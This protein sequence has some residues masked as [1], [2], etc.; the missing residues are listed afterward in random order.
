[1]RVAWQLAGGGVEMGQPDSRA[2]ER[3]GRGR[4]T[5]HP[6]T[7][8]RSCSC[9]GVRLCAWESEVPA[10]PGVL[11][12]ASLAAFRYEVTVECLGRDLSIHTPQQPKT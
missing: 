7:C 12:R 9:C 6:A 3:E 2:R 4:P 5:T 10:G 11:S 8:R 1:V